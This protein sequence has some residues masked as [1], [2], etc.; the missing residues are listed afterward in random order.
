MPVGAA[1]LLQEAAVCE[2]EPASRQAAQGLQRPPENG[3]RLVPQVAARP[4]RARH[5]RAGEAEAAGGVAQ[6]RLEV[7]RQTVRLRRKVEA[8]LKA[9]EHGSDVD[10][11]EAFFKDRPLGLLRA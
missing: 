5:V 9:A 10:E 1:R 6:W 8:R 2:G 11:M 7:V 3:G 4:A